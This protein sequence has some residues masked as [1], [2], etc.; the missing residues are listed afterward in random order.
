MTSSRL[1][2]NLQAN[3]LSIAVEDKRRQNIAFIDLTES[4]PTR[5]GLSYPADLLEAL[6]NAKGLDYD[7]LPLGLWSARAAVAFGGAS[8]RVA[9]GR[10][11]FY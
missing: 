5:V 2:D 4:N 3:A 1:P 8:R 10:W 6:A 7:P 9:T 11:M